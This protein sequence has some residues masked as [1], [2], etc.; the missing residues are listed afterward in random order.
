MSEREWDYTRAAL[1]VQITFLLQG[2]IEAL[3]SVGA[4]G[5]ALRDS[6][7]TKKMESKQATIAIHVKTCP[8]GSGW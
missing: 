1:I 2:L 5:F 4:H 7:E 3:R 6:V 8:E